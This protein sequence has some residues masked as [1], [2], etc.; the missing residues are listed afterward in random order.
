MIGGGI[1]KVKEWTI[2]LEEKEYKVEFYP[3]MLFKFV[4]QLIINDELYRKVKYKLYRKGAEYNFEMDGHKAA[5]VL[6]VEKFKSKYE[7]FI[8]GEAM[9]S[10]EP[11]ICI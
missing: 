9:T 3:S 7:L 5:I 4:F 10:T 2:S 1:L 6:K 11:D 8:D